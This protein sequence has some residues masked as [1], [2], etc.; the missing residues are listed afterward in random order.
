MEI[1]QQLPHPAQHMNT[2]D[3]IQIDA[4]DFYPDINGGLPTKEHE[5]T[6]GLDSLIQ[7]PS[8]KS[9]ECKAPALLQ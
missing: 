4:P 5:E 1:Q 7:Q 2:G 8:E 6:Q 9:D 3:V